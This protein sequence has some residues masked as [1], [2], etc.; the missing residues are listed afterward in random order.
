MNRGNVVMMYGWIQLCSP[1]TYFAPLGES[2]GKGTTT[3]HNGRTS[4]LYERI[5]LRADSLKSIS[6]LE[7]KNGAKGEL[8]DEYQSTN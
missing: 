4:Q 2:H 3:T 7:E 8:Y 5:G 1:G 6:P